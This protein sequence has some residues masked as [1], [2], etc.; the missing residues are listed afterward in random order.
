[1]ESRPSRTVVSVDVW[2]VDVPLRDRF[3]ISRGAVSRAALA[4]VR[5]RL[6]DGTEGYG[7]IAPFTALTG[8]TREESVRRARE[9]A[10]RIVVGSAPDLQTLA[11]ALAAAAPDQPA[12]RCGLECAAADAWARS[13]GEPLWR[14][15]GA[16]DVRPRET[17]V[18]IPILHDGRIDALVAS[19]YARGFRTLKLKVGVDPA[20]DRAR[21]R[22]IAER[23]EDVA[24]VLDA[25]QAF[26]ADGALRFAESLGAHARRVVLFEQPVERGDLD[27]LARV[28][29]GCGMRVAADEAVFTLDDARAVIERGAADVVNLK[30]MKSGLAESLA[31]ADLASGQGVGLMVGGMVETRL[32][33]SFSLAIALGRGGVDH[34]DLDTPLLLCDDPHSGGYAYD[35][36]M[37]SVWHEPGVGAVPA[38]QPR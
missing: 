30:I 8:E 12:A 33:M 15:W 14:A 28:R 19:W 25:N 10:R 1:V 7:E 9:L 18:T 16:S 34:L 11:A 35:G 24:F 2:A 26:D 27:G 32:A 4:F 3:V 23:Y 20:A 29:R 6:D 31:I 38:D 13:L 22:R 5:V 37:L 17:D 21:V 36:P